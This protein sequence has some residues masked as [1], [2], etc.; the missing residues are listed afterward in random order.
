MCLSMRNN[1]R[2]ELSKLNQHE[3]KLL[4]LDHY[5]SVAAGLKSG[6]IITLTASGGALLIGL[7]FQTAPNQVQ[8][9]MFT[10][11]LYTIAFLSIICLALGWYFK[12]ETLAAL[13]EL[14][15]SI[16]KTETNVSKQGLVS[17]VRKIFS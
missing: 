5:F 8:P 14:D 12:R 4:L 1:I 13:I 9:E 10:R 15:N 17:L 6:S 2:C 11:V 3:S 16:Q 7:L